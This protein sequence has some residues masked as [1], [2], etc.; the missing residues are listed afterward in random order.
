MKLEKW[1]SIRVDEKL[2]NEIKKLADKEGIKI[3]EI[4]RK[5]VKEKNLLTKK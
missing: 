4:L 5:W 2:H 3:V 1:M